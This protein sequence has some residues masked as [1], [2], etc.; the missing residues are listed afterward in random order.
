[1]IRV[2]ASPGGAGAGGPLAGRGAAG[3]GCPLATG[4]SAS[5]AVGSG[6]GVSSDSVVAVAVADGAWARVADGVATGD[7]DP[8][9]Q[10]DGVQVPVGAC[11]GVEVPVG[12]DVRSTAA[13][14]EG[15]SAVTEGRVE[16]A[17]TRPNPERPPAAPS[18][19]F[20]TPPASSSL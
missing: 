18:V 17:W 9:G 15:A 8:I 19:R 20:A 13:V 11:E 4:A 14:D 12:S 2:R 10:G 7:D 1:M 16:V 6:V 3:R 5:V